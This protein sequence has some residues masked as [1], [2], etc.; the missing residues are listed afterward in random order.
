MPEPL[1][2]A[3]VHLPIALALLSPFVALAAVVAIARD[4]LPA[5]SW[6]AVVLLQALLAGS[7]WA[8]VETGEGE[9]DRVE[10]VVNPEPIASHEEAAERLLLLAVAGLVV[11]A[12]GL[13]GGS[14]GRYA[15]LAS[16][17]SG[18]V[19][20][21]ATMNTGHLGGE[22]VYRYGAAEAYVEKP[23]GGAPPAGGEHGGHD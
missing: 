12:A 3:V 19:V 7:V 9:E 8:A 1:H 23:A 4:W 14:P 18:A 22:L 17:A 13:L 10:K 2:P 20:L 21:A 16:I 6:I 5:R 11:S 15:R